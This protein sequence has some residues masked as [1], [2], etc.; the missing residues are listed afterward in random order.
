MVLAVATVPLLPREQA[1]FAIFAAVTFLI[2]NRFKGRMVTMFLVMLSLAVSLRYIF[3][4]VTETLTF[5]STSELFLGTLLALAEC[6]AIMVLVLGYIQTVWP[7]ERKPM[8]LPDDVSV[9]PTVD[10]FIPTYNEPMSI[11]RA[12]VL[13]A[14]AMDYPRDK[15]RVHI[16]DDGRRDEFRQFAELCGV[17]YIARPTNEHAKAGN[18]EPCHESDQRR[19]CLR[20]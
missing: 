12:T 18:L 9:W 3:W 10:V 19:V 17:G 16:L 5:N 20:L 13:G 8:P 1:I 14:M 6:Y 7:L 4:R 2:V 15:F 11:V